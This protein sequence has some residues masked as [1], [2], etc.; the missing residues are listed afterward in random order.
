MMQPVGLIRNL[1]LVQCTFA[2]D[3]PLLSPFSTLLYWQVSAP[4]VE[5][6]AH[7]NVNVDSA[8][9]VLAQLVERTRGGRPRP[10]CFSEA[11][12]L[13]RE[14]VEAATERYARL[15]ARL[16]SD[17]RADW[18]AERGKVAACKDYQVC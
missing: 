16:V 2:N 15:L 10:P 4:V 8:F 18:W 12:R 1:I 9:L 13:R 5:T 6:S 11:A 14:A 3:E 17:F 7:E